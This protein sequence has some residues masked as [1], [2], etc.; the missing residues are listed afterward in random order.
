VA[1]KPPRRSNGGFNGRSNEEGAMWSIVG[2]LISGLIIWGGIGWGVDSWLHTH[3]F[4]LVGLLLGLGSSLYL[5][6]LRYGRPL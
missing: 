2:Y 6:W 1:D 3:Y 5:V 4:R